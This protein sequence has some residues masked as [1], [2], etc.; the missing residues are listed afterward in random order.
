[1]VV[2]RLAAVAAAVLATL[3]FSG[4]VAAQDEAP[5][6]GAGTETETEA[7]GEGEGETD[8]EGEEQLPPARTEPAAPGPR[9]CFRALN[10]YRS[11]GEPPEIYDPGLDGDYCFYLAD[12]LRDVPPAAPEQ[13]TVAGIQPRQPD[14]NG[15]QGSPAQTHAA[16]SIEPT[17]LSGGSFALTGTPVGPRILA[18][19]SLNPAAAVSAGES[20]RTLAEASRWTDLAV[21]LPFDPTGSSA[22]PIEFFGVRWRLNFMA[23]PN[24]EHAF[25]L[26]RERLQQSMDRFTATAAGH[27]DRYRRILEAAPNVDGCFLALRARDAQLTRV[28][29]GAGARPE[30][31]DL[32]RVEADLA[33]AVDEVRR[34]ADAFYAGLDVRFDYG[35]TTLS[36]APGADEALSILA[37]AAVGGRIDLSPQWHLGL[38][39]RLGVSWSSAPVGG[40]HQ[41]RT[42]LDGAAAIEVGV[43]L[44]SDRLTL[45]AGIEGR[46]ADGDTLQGA[47]DTNFLDFR[48]ALQAPVSVMNGVGVGV[49]MPLLGAHGV[50]VTLSGDWSLLL[51]KRQ[52]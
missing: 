7:E 9:E 25:T 44:G 12:R 20:V 23:R 4:R 39:G 18:A 51:P 37:S 47:V 16:P 30:P 1:M 42:S 27:A 50:M 21:L 3:A 34:Q 6:E 19:V 5:G 45:S 43:S 33:G 13:L 36:N 17:A 10:R 28:H 22:Q 11:E 52:P 14:A 31:S 2:R 29:C 49:S 48:L 38:R 32:E 35:D 41:S 40:V 24:A 8:P 46:R 15:G 26:A